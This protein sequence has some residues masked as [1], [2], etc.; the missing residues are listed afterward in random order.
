M[1]DL[2]GLES[3]PPKR[4][5]T[6]KTWDEQAKDFVKNLNTL[7]S[8]TWTKPVNSKQSLLDA[9]NPAFSTI[10]YIY[11]LNHHHSLVNKDKGRAEEWINYATVF[12]A[13]FDPVQI[14][15][16]DEQWRYLLDVSFQVL[17]G[18]KIRDLTPIVTGLLR[19]DP[20]GGTFTFNH[21]NL[22]RHCLHV[23][24][25]SQALPL[26]DKD[27]YA[28]PQKHPKSAPEELLNE[29]SEFSTGFI[30]ET[31]AIA[32]KP[33]VEHVLEY[34]LLGASIYIG[35]RKFSRAR[36]FLEYII[37]TPS[38][39]H[40]CSA[41]QME[42]YKKWILLGLLSEGRR[43]PLPRTND[44]QMLKAVRATSKAYEALAEDFEKR[45]YLK[46]LAE[47]QTGNEVWQGDGNMRFVKE[48]GD[49]LFRFRVVDLQK[50]YAA[51]PVS[52]V[53]T[54]LNMQ[55]GSVQQTLSD[56]IRAGQ[57]NA[58]ITP[59]SAG[60]AV[61]RFH[62]S[63]PVKTTTEGDSLEAQTK[64]IEELVASIKD[65]DRRLRLTNEYVTHERRAKRS[66]M[67]PDGD[68]AE[69]MDLTWDAPMGGVQDDDEDGDEDIMAS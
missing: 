36:L 34:Y 30:T 19:L 16:V 33:K 26:L 23:G 5:V 65:A 7:H 58:S 60:D 20:T 1:A 2:K 10:P 4:R 27:I 39:V 12:L 50:T 6:D 14:R 69:Q 40:G 18:L 21:L 51:L 64:R 62:P 17:S 49:A 47:A 3:F 52:R 54:L 57:L 66:G 9:L 15:Y 11:A 38:S 22:V 43:F 35:Q 24:C 8:N 31:S 68:L 44:Q 53:A 42:A 41:F 63:A 48:A 28:F 32:G 45:D 25:P 67:G 46:F 55:A 13:S 37:L 29:E 56:M 61:L 59:S